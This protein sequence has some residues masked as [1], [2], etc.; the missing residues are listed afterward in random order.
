[1]LNG[2]PATPSCGNGNV[3]DCTTNELPV[4]DKFVKPLYDAG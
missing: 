2:G 4:P 1:M 3:E